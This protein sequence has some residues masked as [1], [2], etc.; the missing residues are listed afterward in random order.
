MAARRPI[1]HERTHEI[2]GGFYEV[3]THLGYGLLETVYASALARELEWR[4]FTVEREVWIDVMYKQELV[5]KQRIDMLINHR[6]I[7]EIKA[8]ETIPPFARRQLVNYLRATRVELGLLLH[9]GPEP[10][11]WRLI[12]TKKIQR[13]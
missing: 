10:K 7:V 11:V 13:R 8:T 1:G 4:G 5:A 6:L 2:V 12:D 9:F 3:Y